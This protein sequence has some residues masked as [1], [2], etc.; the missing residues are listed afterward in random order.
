M[1]I[2][3][4][5][6]NTAYKH[7]RHYIGSAKSVKERLERHRKGKGA[8]LM[9]VIAAANIGFVLARTWKG[10]KKE[11]RKLK[12]RKNAPRLCP[13]CQGRQRKG[14]SSASPPGSQNLKQRQRYD[15]THHHS[16]AGD[17]SSG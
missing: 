2:Y 4:I 13:I 1:T 10:G 6:F 7:A 14:L 16:K 11:E 12:N 5:H 3:L 9:E 15:T 8:R 17:R